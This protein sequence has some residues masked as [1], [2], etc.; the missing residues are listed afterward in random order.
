MRTSGLL[1]FFVHAKRRGALS[2]LPV[3]SQSKYLV[4][5]EVV[6]AIDGNEA[7]RLIQLVKLRGLVSVATIDGRVCAGMICF[8][9]GKSRRSTK[10]GRHQSCASS[11]M[12]L[13]CKAVIRGETRNV[14]GDFHIEVLCQ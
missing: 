8:Q 13:F 7:E 14:S 10:T 6:S 3:L 2:E 12:F 5:V 11:V 4:V 9:I 1:T